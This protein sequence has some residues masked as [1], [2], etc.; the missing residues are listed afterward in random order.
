MDPSTNNLPWTHS[1]FVCGQD[2]P[3]GLK[4]RARR[5]GDRV[6]LDHEVRFEDSGW[7]GV[8]HG[9]LTMTLMDEVMTWAAILR[10]GTGCVSAEFTARLRK[11]IRA[12][13]RLRV[14]GW[15][16]ELRRR[17]MVV[18]GRVLSA[19]GEVLS[20]ATGKY[21]TLSAEQSQGF[22]KDFVSRAQGGLHGVALV[23]GVRPQ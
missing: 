11:P 2:N 23:P 22:S 6:V 16:G 4:L 19:S 1:C 20:E 7:K 3:H 14:E 10:S 15:A 17:V 12:A 5:E 13:E 9:G 18:E 8:M 21:V